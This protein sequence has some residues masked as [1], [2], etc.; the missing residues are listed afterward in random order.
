M[1]VA[2]FVAWFETSLCRIP[3]RPGPGAVS[4]ITVKTRGCVSHDGFVIG[5]SFALDVRTTRSLQR[6]SGAGHSLVTEIS[7]KKKQDSRQS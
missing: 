6:G 5:L 3:E 4:V 1:F 7:G 2:V